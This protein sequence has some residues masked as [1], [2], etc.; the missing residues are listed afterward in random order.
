MSVNAKMKAIADAIRGKTG[1]TDALTL[2]QMAT[3]IA[4][5]ETGG[6]L[7]T[8]AVNITANGG[9]TITRVVYITVDDSGNVQTVYS[10]PST[11]ACSLR[12]LCNSFV[13]VLCTGYSSYSN[14][15]VEFIDN[16][17]G[18]N[19]FKITATKDETAEIQ[20]ISDSGGGGGGSA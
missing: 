2:D 6:S 8:C 4:G 9:C 5:I 10:K 17:N 1:G 19:F 11:T 20:Y 15:K 13:T 14:N 18:V 12:C 7:D 3:E 16:W